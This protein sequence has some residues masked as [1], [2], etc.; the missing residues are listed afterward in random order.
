ME[1]WLGVLMADGLLD[2]RRDDLAPYVDD[3]HVNLAGP[4]AMAVAMVVS[5]PLFSNQTLYTGL[6]PK[7]V[8]SI[9]DI[10]FEVGF[11]IAFAL[12]AGLRSVLR[13]R[14]ATTLA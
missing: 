6:V 5:I 13:S 8:P 12:Y 7:A 2:K 14:T 11:V 3:R 10:A 1:P 9:G 4:I